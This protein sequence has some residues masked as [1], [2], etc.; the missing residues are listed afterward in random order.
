MGTAKDKL[1]HLHKRAPQR[2]LEGLNAYQRVVAEATAA[3][4]SPTS[5]TEIAQLLGAQDE[6]EPVAA[7][8]AA[9]RERALMWGP[10]EALH[11]VRAVR[12]AFE[13]YPG[14]LAPPSYRML[15]DTQIRERLAAC[16]EAVGPV[17]DRLAWSPSGAVRN[18]TRRSARFAR[19]DRRSIQ[20]FAP[21]TLP[22]GALRSKVR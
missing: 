12:E 9:L 16:D 2:A 1:I 8:V 11:L 6:P 19:W 13:P 5:V 7:A 10:D 3:L 21:R 18:A 20:L 15:S 17:L 22:A 4:S 14:G